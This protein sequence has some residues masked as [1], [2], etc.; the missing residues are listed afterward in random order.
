MH[1]TG[2]GL[3]ADTVDGI[4]ATA[5]TQSG[6][7]V[8]LT[9]D[10]TGSTTVGADG[11]ISVATTI[12][13]NSVELGT[14]TT[15]NYVASLTAGNLIDLQNN[16]G[17]N[18]TPTIDVDL[19]ELTDMTGVAVGTDELDILD[20]GSQKRKAINEITLGLF[21]TT[22]Q[23]ALGTDTTGNYVTQGATSGN[24]ISGSVNSEGGTFTAVSYTHLTLPTKRIV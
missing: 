13:A 14:D 16:S 6:D 9:G 23:I 1:G 4:E 5:I 17:E 8:A 11:S 19:S 22:N 3:D 15:G 18:A 10:V 20:D 12:A 21:N 24:G 7:T 2:S